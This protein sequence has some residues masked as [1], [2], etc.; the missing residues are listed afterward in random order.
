MCRLAEKG[1][2]RLGRGGGAVVRVHTLDGQRVA[3][4]VEHPL[5][6]RYQTVIAE[7]QVQ[8]LKQK[9]RVELTKLPLDVSN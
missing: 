5:V 8:V 9:V 7:E 4:R 2:L 1:S 6:Q 3:L